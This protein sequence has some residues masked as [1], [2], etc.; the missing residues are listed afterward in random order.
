MSKNKIQAKDILIKTQQ[1][2]IV[3]LT[4]E[5]YKLMKE[6]SQLESR[7]KYYLSNE[8]KL[9]K[10]NKKIEELNKKYE[11][12]FNEKEKELNDFKAKYDKLAHEKEYE[13]Q[14]YNT[15]ISIYNQK[16]SLIHHTEMENEIYRDEVK[17]LKEENEQL[18]NAVKKR[19]ESL[20]IKNTLKYNDLKKKMIEHLNEAKKNVS[21]L[22][23]NYMDINSRISFLQNHEL[24]KQ[25]EN[26]KQNNEELLEINKVL[27]KQIS[28]L[29]NDIEIHK[30]IEIN[31]VLKI[32]AK[33]KEAKE[34][35]KESK[36]KKKCIS[37][38][39]Y[40]S[41]MFSNNV[42]DKSSS[43]SPLTNNS[44]NLAKLNSSDLKK[45][46]LIN[47]IAYQDSLIKYLKRENNFTKLTSK[48]LTSYDNML[49]SK[50][51]ENNFSNRDSRNHV[52]M[53]SGPEMNYIKYNKIIKD[54]NEQI[55]NLKIKIDSLNHKINLNFDKYKGLFKFLEECL[56]DFFNDE[57][58]QN[59]K[60]V[61]INMESIRKFDFNDFN[62]EEKY[63]IF[64]L[65]MNYLKPL[66][67][68]NYKT[69]S[70]GNSLFKTNINIISKSN[71][72]AKNYLNNRYPSL[73][74]GEVS[75]VISH[76]NSQNENV[77]Y[78]FN[79]KNGGFVMVAADKRVNPIL[80]YSPENN[81]QE[82]VPAVEAFVS[83]YEAE[84]T[85]VKAEIF[86]PDANVSAK[87]AELEEGKIRKDIVG[88]DKILLTCKWNQDKYYNALCPYMVESELTEAQDAGVTLS[89]YDYH[90]PNGCVALAMAQIMYYH[91]YPRK[92]SASH[93]YTTTKYGKLSANFANTQYDYEAM[94]DNVYGY[95]DAVA[96]LIYHCGVGVN[97]GYNGKGSG[98]SWKECLSA[99]KSYF[100]YKN[101]VHY[102]RYLYADNVW[103]DMLKTQIDSGWP[104]YYHACTAAGE[105][106]RDGCHAFVIDGYQQDNA[107]NFVHI[108][109]GWA[110]SNDGFYTLSTMGTTRTG[111]YTLNSGAI[112]NLK[113]L[114]EEENFFTGTDTLTANFGSFN[115]GSGRLPYKSNTNCSWLISPQ[116]GLG[117]N[118]I[119]LKVSAFET[120][121]IN[122]YVRIYAGKTATGTPIATLSGKIAAGTTYT[123]NASEAFV[124]FVSNGSTEKD[125]FTFTYTSTTSSYG[126]CNS[127]INPTT[128]T[129][130]T[131]TITNIGTTPYYNS[132]IC[133][134]LIMPTISATT[135]KVGIVFTKFNLG[136][137]DWIEIY[138]GAKNT[139]GTR[140]YTQ[141]GQHRFTVEEPPVLGQV[142]E[143]DFQGAYVR[144]FA[145]NKDNASGFEL[146]WHGDVGIREINA[147][148]TTLNIYPNPANNILNVEIETEELENVTLTLCDILG[149]EL[150]TQQISAMQEIS[151]YRIDVS[152]LAKGMYLLRVK[153]NKGITTKKFNKQ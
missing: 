47:K 51:K 113:P 112:M 117:V 19:L 27:N 6:K 50:E 48:S 15:N 26:L 146:Q 2:R 16:M 143:V 22:N 45:N 98:A 100:S 61:N 138:K 104:V 101:A 76:T 80:A 66:L 107:D 133:N 127:N 30:K 10:A 119:I 92:G 43:L 96:R 140:N 28:D 124:Q 137:G 21:K 116:N 87:W 14:K 67:N 152:D 120:D 59:I 12:F 35:Q 135:K 131:G 72:S 32:K 148:M 79:F 8:E 134:W 110:G 153:T 39:K 125:G 13:S 4:Y 126:Q 91:R 95:S 111:Y 20:N 53:T 81:Y 109:F 42:N 62:K 65:L 68:F 86:Q 108:N 89:T 83:A 52:S 118:Q 84:I 36:K 70:F 24:I 106:V 23:L 63:S 41:T 94:T 60:N 1:E 147:G 122:D 129:D 85:D 57:E 102:D 37:L 29:K 71:N 103:F 5:N 139:G 31:L 11:D 17:E 105:Q 7:L 142:Y 46:D 97:M 114:N 150:K 74:F 149:K 44:S 75:E 136:K 33:E 145:D 93:Q 73:S 82:K 69:N 55:E 88:P 99:F 151:T 90:V 64:I 9:H 77:Y 78:V 25:I 34:N 40:N 49:S 18:K 123:I 38:N 3:T 144:F 115:D 56:N 128:L 58:I 132:N 121:T 130:N 141:W 54:K